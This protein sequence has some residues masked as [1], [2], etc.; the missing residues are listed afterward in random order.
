MK[1][2]FARIDL[3]L[4]DLDITRIKGDLAEGYSGTFMNYYIKDPEYLENLIKEKIQFKYQPNRVYYTE[5]RGQGTEPHI[6]DCMTALNYYL[7]TDEEGVVFFNHNPLAEP[8][9]RMSDIDYSYTITYKLKDLEPIGYFQSNNHEAWL[10][11]TKCVHGVLKR[12][13]QR[14]RSMIR[15]MWDRAPYSVV[16]RGIHIP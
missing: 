7:E 6:D 2:Y 8:K 14:T 13:S 16:H 12:D 4:K 3:D 1:D 5:L 9:K 15:W 11:N 10:L